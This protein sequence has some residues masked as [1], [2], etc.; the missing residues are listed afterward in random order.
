VENGPA[1]NPFE[2][3]EAIVSVICSPYWY[4]EGVLGIK[5]PGNGEVQTGVAPWQMEWRANWARD[6]CWKDQD[7]NAARTREANLD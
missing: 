5:R 4:A 2:I 3:Q 7:G 6:L 1:T